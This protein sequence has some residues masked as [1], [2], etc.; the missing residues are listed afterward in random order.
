MAMTRTR[1]SSGQTLSLLRGLLDRPRKWR[2]GYDLSQD[3]GLPSGTLYP[4][5]VRLADRG[6]LESKWEAA[7][8]PG[9]PPRHLYRLT[10]KGSAYARSELEADEVSALNAPEGSRA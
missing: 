4:I 3:T 5:L 1:R 7:P 10:A 6:L 8:D 2:H 9:R